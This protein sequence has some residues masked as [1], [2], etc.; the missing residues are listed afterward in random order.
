ME[1]KINMKTYTDA[2]TYI[3]AEIYKKTVNNGLQYFSEFAF[4]SK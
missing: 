1:T 2:N 4:T 3:G